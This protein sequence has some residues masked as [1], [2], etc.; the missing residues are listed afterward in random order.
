MSDTAPLSNTPAPLQLTIHPL[1]QK[2]QGTFLSGTNNTPTF[3]DLLDTI[4]PLQHI[5]IVSNIYQSLTGDA[6]STGATLAG[7]TLF[8]GALGFAASLFNVILK[9]ATGADLEGNIMAAIEGKPVPALQASGT[10][11]VADNGPLNYM[12]ASQRTNYNAYVQAGMLA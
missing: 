2:A 7:D 5:P 3:K 10:T 11:Q 6:P 8:G 1:P 9:N 4:N 12:S